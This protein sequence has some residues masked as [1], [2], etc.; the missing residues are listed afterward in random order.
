MLHFGVE[1]AGI[2]TEIIE[3][4]FSK[5]DRSLVII[6]PDPENLF[7]NARGAIRKYWEKDPIDQTAPFREHTHLIEKRLED[8][9][10]EELLVL[11]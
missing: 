2:N 7:E 11:I 9:A 4:F 8:V 6:H 5:P 3:W 10:P 1:T